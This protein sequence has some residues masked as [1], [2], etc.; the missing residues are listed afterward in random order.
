MNWIVL[1]LVVFGV[2]TLLLIIGVVAYTKWEGF[3]RKSSLDSPRADPYW[4]SAELGA[5]RYQE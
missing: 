4:E 1:G 5:Y 3:E 2:F